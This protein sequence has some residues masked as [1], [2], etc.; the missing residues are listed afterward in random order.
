MSNETK[1]AKGGR[2]AL[3]TLGGSIIGVLATWLLGL[4]EM[5]K[6]GQLGDQA[7]QYAA[8][9]GAVGGFLANTL[10]LVWQQY[11]GGSSES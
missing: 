5:A 10:K 11:R 2:S 4:G 9:L 7:V 8:V 1:L 6:D 3:I